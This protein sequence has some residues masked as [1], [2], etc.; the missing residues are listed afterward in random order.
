MSV[1]PRSTNDRPLW[2]NAV[3]DKKCDRVDSAGHAGHGKLRPSTYSRPARS[4]V[5]VNKNGTVRERCRVC[6]QKIMKTTSPLYHAP[7]VRTGN[8]EL[9]DGRELGHVVGT[10]AF[11]THKSTTHRRK[12]DE[13]KSRWRA[14]TA[15][16]ISEASIALVK[17]NEKKRRLGGGTAHAPHAYTAG[18]RGTVQGCPVR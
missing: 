13:K 1:P 8:N 16:R 14:C 7:G 5:Q 17:P 11:T 9:H 3:C 6:I 12:A 18:E 15:S 10:V 2:R 4:P